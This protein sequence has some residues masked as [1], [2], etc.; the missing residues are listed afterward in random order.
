MRSRNFRLDNG[1][2][3]SWTGRLKPDVYRHPVIALDVLPT[4]LA[5]TGG[6]L[7]TDRSYYGVNPLPFLMGNNSGI[8]HETLFWR[9]RDMR[10]QVV[11]HG[12]WKYMNVRGQVS[13]FDIQADPSETKDIAASRQEIVND[14][15][16]RFAAWNDEM[17]EPL[18][19]FPAE[20]RAER[21]A[22]RRNRNAKD[23][24]D[25]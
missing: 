17:T 8:P 4:A 11:R 10:A 14:L 24:E 1:L 5:A 22:K 6:R 12:P 9:M 7:P 19:S 13:L 18:W 3:T 23:R 15:A 2:D 21:R 20:E 16:T 25:K